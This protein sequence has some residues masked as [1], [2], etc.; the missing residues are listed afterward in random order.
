MELPP[1]R[2]RTHTRGLKSLAERLEAVIDRIANDET[3]SPELLEFVVWKLSLAL[4]GLQRRLA[5][6]QRLALAARESDPQT[7]RKPFI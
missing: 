7:L 2:K 3:I 1:C 6:D 5:R 4:A